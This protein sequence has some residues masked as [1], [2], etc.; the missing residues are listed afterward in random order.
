M[1]IR[2]ARKEQEQKKRLEEIKKIEEKKEK[3]KEQKQ[4]EKDL[5]IA[6]ENDL[7]NC[8]MNCFERE[9]LQKGYINLRLLSTRKEIIENVGENFAERQYIDENYEK[10]LSKVKQIYENDQK[11]KSEYMQ[12][13]LLEEQQKQQEEEQK[14]QEKE[15]NK[16]IILNI[17]CYLVQGI[18]WLFIILFGGIYLIFKFIYELANK[19]Y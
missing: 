4:Y 12:L 9:G 8:F 11:A 16:N 19:M 6:V 14:Q 2:E 13:Q 15:Q 7:K 1:N 18:K 10:I 3:E 17:L 5:K